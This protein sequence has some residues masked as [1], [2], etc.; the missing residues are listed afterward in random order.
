MIHK[1]SQAKLKSLQRKQNQNHAGEEYS[2]KQGFQWNALT[3]IREIE[4]VEFPCWILTCAKC[5]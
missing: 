2:V 4:R 5:S 3:N 1:N